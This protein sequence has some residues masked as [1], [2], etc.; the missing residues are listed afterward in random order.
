M[1]PCHNTKYP[2][3]FPQVRHQP[4]CVVPTH[5][6]TDPPKPSRAHPCI[7]RKHYCQAL[8]VL[9]TLHTAALSEP[10]R[11]QPLAHRIALNRCSIPRAP[12]WFSGRTPPLVSTRDSSGRAVG[13]V[14]RTTRKQYS[15]AVPPGDRKLCGR[16]VIKR[17]RCFSSGS[18]RRG[19]AAHSVIVVGEVWLSNC[20]M[21]HRR[22]AATP[23]ESH[24]VAGE[25]AKGIPTRRHIFSVL[26]LC[27]GA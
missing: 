3:P 2:S 25:V 16:G 1:S 20:C 18:R 12:R 10:R 17:T 22:V 7:Q 26:P 19:P 23:P 13:A 11:G 15:V 14:R 21:A 27:F 24:A 6:P 5:R 4:D 8:R 9:T